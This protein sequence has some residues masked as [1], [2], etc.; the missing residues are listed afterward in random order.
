[1]PNNGPLPPCPFCK[2]EEV[3]IETVRIEA[4]GAS[5]PSEEVAYCQ[6]C[7]ANAPEVWWRKLEK[8]NAT[9]TT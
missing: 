9:P 6:D 7:G 1:M 3:T 8:A 5:P 2:C 4:L